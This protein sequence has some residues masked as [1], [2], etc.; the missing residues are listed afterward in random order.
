MQL[1]SEEQIK[2]IIDVK[3]AIESAK[4]TYKDCEEEKFTQE[5]AFICQSVEKQM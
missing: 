2:E 1:Y 3:K 4:E 5:T